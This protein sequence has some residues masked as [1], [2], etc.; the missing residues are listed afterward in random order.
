MEIIHPHTTILQSRRDRLLQETMRPPQPVFEIA[1]EYPIVLSPE[2]PHFSYCAVHGDDIKA[3]ANLW[4]RRLYDQQQQKYFQV[5]LIG[6]VATDPRWQGHGIMKELFMRLH[7]EA[8]KL[9]LDAMIL[10][11]D[12][13]QFYQKLGFGSLG[14]ELRIVF[15][16]ESLNKLFK[17]QNTGQFLPHPPAE[18]TPQSY[19]AL[20]KLRYPTVAT[21]ERSID[22]FKSLMKIPETHLY[23][24]GEP[25]SAFAII[26]KGYDMIG[27]VHEWGASAP[28]ILMK[29]IRDVAE[30]Q[31]FDDVILLCPNNLAP[32]WLAE[33][34]KVAKDVQKHDMALACPLREDQKLKHALAAC[35]IWGLDSI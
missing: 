16:R 10:W 34:K 13:R 4:P 2:N 7:Q 14:Q 18:L 3:H 15:E 24:Q 29:G 33:F 23:M 35:F 6:N 26:G 5:G 31:K 22:E 8:L 25:P 28:D 21:L 20:L 9:G 17:K 27:V 19:D 30:D 11:S 32:E 1:A 12:L